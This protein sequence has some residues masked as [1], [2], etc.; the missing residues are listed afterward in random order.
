MYFLSF[1]TLVF[2]IKIHC[3]A[4]EEILEILEL[5]IKLLSVF[6]NTNNSNIKATTIIQA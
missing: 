1:N 2:D 5:S 4:S 3:L 6:I